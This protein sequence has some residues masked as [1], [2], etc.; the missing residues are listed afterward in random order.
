MSEA[1]Q[2]PESKALTLGQQRVAAVLASGEARSVTHAA[3]L[4]GVD[5]TTVWRLQRSAAGQRE[6]ARREALQAGKAKSLKQ[7]ASGKLAERVASDDASDALLLGTYKTA[8]DVLASGVEEDA[9]EGA[10]AS[11]YAAA[12]KKLMQAVRVGMYLQRRLQR[13]SPPR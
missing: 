7:L 5:R 12:R 3:E 4:A 9:T 8:N 1:P 13:S 11:D 10:S 2:V 6:I